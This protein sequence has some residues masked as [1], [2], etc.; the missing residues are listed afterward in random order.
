MNKSLLK[1]YAT[2]LY[3]VAKENDNVEQVRNDLDFLCQIFKTNNDFVKFLSSEMILKVDKEKVLEKELKD[4]VSKQFYAFINV[5]IRRKVI[6]HMDAIKDLFLKV[7]NRDHGI[8]EGRIYT[9]FELDEKRIKEL[10]DIFSE[11]FSSRVSFRTIIDK[12]ILAGM[13]IYVDD[14]LFDYSLDTKI[15]KVRDKLLTDKK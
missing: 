3:S 2:A 9:P 5:C 12:R 15:N 4:K 11:K 1:S 7:Y 13:K 6:K 10:E 14:T 8:K